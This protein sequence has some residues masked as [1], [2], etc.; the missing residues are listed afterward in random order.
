MPKIVPT[1]LKKVTLTKKATRKL[2]ELRGG[3][4]TENVSEVVSHCFEDWVAVTGAE[5]GFATYV[6]QVLDEK[7]L[8]AT[9]QKIADAEIV[10]EFFQNVPDDSVLGMLT[11]ELVES[12]LEG[13]VVRPY[14]E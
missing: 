10:E 13:E 5:N 1:G 6:T 14:G 2:E 3:H 4:D 11:G 9:T 7:G 12:I 8:L